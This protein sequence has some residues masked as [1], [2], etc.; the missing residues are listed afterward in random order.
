MARRNE[1]ASRVPRCLCRL[2]QLARESRRVRLCLRR[3]QQLAREQESGVSPT[4]ARVPQLFAIARETAPR[5][6]G[7]AARLPPV[8]SRALRRSRQI[9]SEQSRH[10]GPAS[11]RLLASVVFMNRTSSAVDLGADLC[12]ST[13]QNVRWPL[14]GRIGRFDSIRCHVERLSDHRWR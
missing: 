9:T 7:V 13:A 8:V 12:H 6:L 1:P 14:P 5:A 10:D 11:R 3:L 4:S 2:Q